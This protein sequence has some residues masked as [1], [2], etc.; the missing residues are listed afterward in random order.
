MVR[1]HA[2]NSGGGMYCEKRFET[3]LTTKKYTTAANVKFTRDNTFEKT[4]LKDV[5]LNNAYSYNGRFQR[6]IS[7]VTTGLHGVE[8]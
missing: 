1:N 2:E 6:T 8:A 4:S 5:S 3:F 7:S